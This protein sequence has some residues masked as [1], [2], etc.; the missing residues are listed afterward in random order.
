MMLLAVR[1]DTLFLNTPTW[2]ETE[3]A[4]LKPVK[5]AECTYPSN[6]PH[7]RGGVV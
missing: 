2:Y 3:L 7:H 1:P 6:W 5:T 4:G